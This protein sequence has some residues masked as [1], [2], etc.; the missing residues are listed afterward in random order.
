MAAHQ[1][2]A[3]KIFCLCCRNCEEPHDINVS[4]VPSQTQ[5]HQPSPCNLKLQKDELNRQSP[6][7]TKAT[8]S[9]PAGEP[10]IHPEKRGSTSSSEF[11]DLNDQASQT[12]FHKRNLNRYSQNQWPFQPCLIGRP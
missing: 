6:K 12:G 2:L 5:E 1:N 3:S 8:S 10:L 11:E 9:L 4:K 7:H